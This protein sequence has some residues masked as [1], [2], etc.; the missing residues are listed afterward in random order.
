VIVWTENTVA[1][2]AHVAFSEAGLFR[3]SVVQPWSPRPACQE[4]ALCQRYYEKSYDVDVPPGTVGA[5]NDGIQTS[6][7]TTAFFSAA[8]VGFHTTKFRQS[9]PVIYNNNDGV[10]GQVSE[11]NSGN[12]F[13]ANRTAGVLSGMQ[14]GATLY[15]PSASM[16]AHNLIRFHWSCDAEL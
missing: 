15:Q 12:A 13:V 10:T 7:A 9:N 16:T 3:D 2:S 8:T 5:A 4:L 11:Y 6:A 14:N 1:T